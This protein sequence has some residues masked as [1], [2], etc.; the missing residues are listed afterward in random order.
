MSKNTNVLVT[1]CSG[2]IGSQTCK[3]LKSQGFG[4]VGID[5]EAPR[6][7]TYIDHFV[8]SDFNDVRTY[9]ALTKYNIKTVIHIAAKSLVGPSV[10]DPNP[11]YQHNVGNLYSL[12]N[13]CNNAGVNRIV[14][15]SSAAVYGDQSNELSETVEPIPCNPYGHTKLIGEWILNDY[16][17]AYEFDTVA[18]RYFNVCGADPD[19]EFG[20]V[21]RPTHIIG[22][23]I[24]RAL[25]GEQLTIN[26]DDFNTR[27][28]TCVRD[29]VHVCDVARANVLAATV[30]HQGFVACNISTGEGYSN[31]EIANA[32]VEHTDIDLE[33]T[34]GPRRAGDPAVLIGDNQLAQDILGWEPEMSDLPTIVQTAAEWHKSNS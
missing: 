7:D 6:L 14:F 33:Y 23:A 28:G 3:E 21:G 13:H 30:P 9:Y 2:Y 31:L 12:L 18:L 16:A 20:Q 27:D 26:G 1:G 22:A 5:L 10:K 15:S 11:Y 29:Y 4:V 24:T 32:I 8:K 17:Q 19:G 34:F 25:N